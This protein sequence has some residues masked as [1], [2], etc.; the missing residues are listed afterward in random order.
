[1]NTLPSVAERER[2][3]T[4]SCKDTSIQSLAHAQF[5]LTAHGGHRCALYLAAQRRASS[6]CG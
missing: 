5:C 6:V 4:Q 2:W 1:M 3:Q